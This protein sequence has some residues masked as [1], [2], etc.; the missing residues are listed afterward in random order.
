MS[1]QITVKVGSID[2]LF[3]VVNPHD[4]VGFELKCLLALR[5]R[6][7]SDSGLSVGGR[8]RLIDDI[9]VDRGSGWWHFR[10]SLQAGAVGRVSEIAFSSKTGVMLVAWVPDVEWFLTTRHG[11]REWESRPGNSSFMMLATHFEPVEVDA[12][13][14]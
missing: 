5:D 10:R 11:E 3:E 4:G 12:Y 13:S 9:D 7:I 2:E 8:A 6:V 1:L 14:I